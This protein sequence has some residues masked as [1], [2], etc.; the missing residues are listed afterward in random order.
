MSGVISIEPL[1]AAA[2]EPF[3]DVIELRAQPDLWINQGRCGRHNDL[4]RLD[5]SDGRAGISLFDAEPQQIP[6][7]LDMVER[8]PIGSQA[9]LPMTV[10]PF[11]AIV[12]PNGAGTPGRPRAF[13]TTPGQGVNYRRGTW[14]GVLTP[15]HPGLFAVIDRIGPGANL[16]EHWFDKPWVIDGPMP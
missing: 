6:V 11:L 3:G 14:H 15:L 16:E 1:T 2:F 7:S 9:F 12:A 13:L 10:H 4:T 8:H 5:F